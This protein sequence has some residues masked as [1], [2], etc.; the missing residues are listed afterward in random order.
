MEKKNKKC[1]NCKHGGKQF[2]VADKTH[3]H[4]EHPKYTREDFESGKISPWDTLCEFWDVC[5]DYELKQID[6]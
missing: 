4:C 2:K 5:K 3:L 6:S 1:Y